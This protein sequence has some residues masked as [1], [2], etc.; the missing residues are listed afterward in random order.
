MLVYH[1][2]LLLNFD[3]EKMTSVCISQDIIVKKK[4]DEKIITFSNTKKYKYIFIFG[5]IYSITNNSVTLNKDITE[6]ALINIMTY[7]LKLMVLI[8][9]V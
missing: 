3:K 4:N 8:I 1:Q 7:P 6:N 9:F 2:K 5:E